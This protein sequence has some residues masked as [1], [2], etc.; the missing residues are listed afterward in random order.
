MPQWLLP[1][2]D[3]F[4]FENVPPS[5]MRVDMIQLLKLEFEIKR[6]ISNE[7]YQGVLPQTDGLGT[8]GS[9]Y[10]EA[11]LVGKGQNIN[12]AEAGVSK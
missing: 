4:R 3:L 9:H 1:R 6:F 2:R 7:L 10:M 12:S 5:L 8:I 11:C